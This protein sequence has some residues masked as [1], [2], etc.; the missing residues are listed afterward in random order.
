LRIAWGRAGGPRVPRPPLKLP[1]PP[2][3]M[4][5]GEGGARA[6]LPRP[7]KTKRVKFEM[8]ELSF[9]FVTEDS[10][11]EV[12]EDYWSQAQKAYKCGVFAGVVV[13]CGAVLEGLLAWAITCHEQEARKRF[14]KEFKQKDGT[15]KPISK[16][17]LTPL[18]K[19][20]KKL[21]LIGRASVRLLEVIQDFRNF[22]HPYNVVQQSA[23]PDEGLAEISLRTVEEVH[24]SLTGR[25]IKLNK[26]I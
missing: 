2:P 25:I 24:R 12:I 16:W 14:P 21:D 22:I 8:K 19:V 15:E 10:I 18:I 23:R 6:R 26:M 3:F 13:L 20:A 1:S 4:G 5:A 9:S 11:R 17:S 7:P